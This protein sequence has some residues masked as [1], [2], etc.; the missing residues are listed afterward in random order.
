MDRK[1]RAKVWIADEYKK[2]VQE[3]P[4][5]K[6]T[7]QLLCQRCG[8]NRGTFYYHFRDIFDLQAWIFRADVMEPVREEIWRNREN[9]S[10]SSIS[11]RPMITLMQKL[12]ENKSLYR[13]ALQVQE[14]NIFSEVMLQETSANWWPI[15]EKIKAAEGAA[16]GRLTEEQET[17]AANI[18]QYYSYAHFQLVL[19]WIREG[20]K[21]EPE[22]IAMLLDTAAL[23]GLFRALYSVLEEKEQG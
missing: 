3:M 9:T 17:E 4:M 15:W 21:I 5:K 1:D 16:D 12:Y 23:P 14:P 18:L 7:V 13:Q 2:L 10:L 20:M 8:I 11:S 6:V 19:R 22:R